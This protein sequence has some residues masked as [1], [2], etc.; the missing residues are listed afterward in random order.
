MG[1]RRVAGPLKSWAQPAAIRRGGIG[2]GPTAGDKHND[3]ERD[4]ATSSVPDG[5]QS[6]PGKG[7]EVYG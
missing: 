3:E 1:K 5:T 4:S 6:A 2:T 7:D